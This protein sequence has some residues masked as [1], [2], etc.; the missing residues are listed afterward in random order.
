MNKLI[1]T[2]DDDIYSFVIHTKILNTD[3]LK[4]ILEG[5][6]KIHKIHIDKNNNTSRFIIDCTKTQLISLNNINIESNLINH[7][8][9]I[10]IQYEYRKPFKQVVR[11]RG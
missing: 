2:L 6:L 9:R 7:I 11:V 5:L 8:Q 10:K 3:K 1:D 4:N